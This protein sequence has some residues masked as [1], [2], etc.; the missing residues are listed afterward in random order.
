MSDYNISFGEAQIEPSAGVSD[1]DYQKAL[2]GLRME[3]A[4]PGTIDIDHLETLAGIVK[5]YRAKKPTSSGSNLSDK[6]EQPIDTSIRYV[7][8]P[9]TPPVGTYDGSADELEKNAAEMKQ[10]HDANFGATDNYTGR[11]DVPPASFTPPQ[12]PA[13]GILDKLAQAK[14]AL[15]RALGGKVQHI[16]EP[17]VL[18]F[19]NKMRPYYGA[20]V[21]HMTKNDKEYGQYA[22]MRWKE[23]YDKA[24]TE[25]IPVVRQAYAPKSTMND[26]AGVAGGLGSALAGAD[27]TFTFGLGGLAY[28]KLEEAT[29][30]PSADQIRRQVRST[31]GAVAP[32]LDPA[33]S[34]QAALDAYPISG[35]L[36]EIA[37]A[38]HPK[39]LVS[40]TGGLLGAG[41]R[42]A[43][44]KAATGVAGRIAAG[45]LEGAGASAIGSAGIDAV[46]SLSDPSMTADKIAERAKIAAMIGLPLGAVGGAI[47]AHGAN[48]REGELGT[49]GPG[50]RTSVRSGI[51]PASNEE[52]QVMAKYIDRAKAEP[53][54]PK[55]SELMLSELEKPVVNHAVESRL[56]AESSIGA[57]KVAAHAENPGLMPTSDLLKAATKAH[58][59]GM[60]SGGKE[61]AFQANLPKLRAQIANLADVKPVPL[62]EEVQGAI[63]VKDAQRMGFDVS[64]ALADDAVEVVIRPRLVTLEKLDE[65]ISGLDQMQKAGK[66]TAEPLPGYNDMAKAARDMRDRFS[67]E[68]SAQQ[69][70]S[71]RGLH[72]L[73]RRLQLSGIPQ[74]LKPQGLDANQ[75]K[76]L[77]GSLGSYGEPGADAVARNRAIRET[78]NLSGVGKE[79][80]RSRQ[81]RAY[82]K[83]REEAKAGSTP[84]LF[85]PLKVGTS[86]PVRL[87]ADA[88]AQKFQLENLGNLGSLSSD[89]GPQA[90]GQRAGQAAQGASRATIDMISRMLNLGSPLP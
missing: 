76:A 23:I 54:A 55:A 50:F 74:D 44:G 31:G 20:A 62:G 8:P 22:D 80:E 86:T 70:G 3:K 85:R 57:D 77:M 15:P 42:G 12:P 60:D 53:G 81:M 2:R 19:Q 56:A 26:L 16:Y 33:P 71:G 34:R 36:G 9:L 47:G 73:E 39:S 43:A 63:L 10:F 49:A 5:E 52:G 48:L 30:H 28:D 68:Y 84:S 78:A 79:L 90:L 46:D 13:A 11:K 18:E 38:L 4:K 6:H 7:K 1:D 61:L 69:G 45:A 40:K 67:R 88:L 29:R 35:G 32:D 21:D 66:R 58:A 37:G 82:E 17:S 24:Q 59:A 65:V 89:E 14:D 83:L 51:K 64:K 41:I 75:H 27:K 72:D 87:R 25:G